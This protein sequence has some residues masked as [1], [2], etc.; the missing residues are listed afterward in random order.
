MDDCNKIISLRKDIDKIW[1]NCKIET[2][3]KGNINSR[4]DFCTDTVEMIKKRAF[5]SRDANF[6]EARG[7]E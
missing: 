3:L 7:G 6:I 2:S 5:E 1:L 4:L